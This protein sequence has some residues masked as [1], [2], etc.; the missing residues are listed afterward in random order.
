MVTS[1]GPHQHQPLCDPRAVLAVRDDQARARELGATPPQGRAKQPGP[2]TPGRAIRAEGES[3]GGT[4]QGQAET[5]ARPIAMGQ[6]ARTSAGSVPTG[7]GQPW[8]TAMAMV[9]RSVSQSHSREG[10]T[11]S[12][13]SSQLVLGPSSQN[14]SCL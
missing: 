11:L 9:S 4:G 2:I 12:S 7:L 8:G 1:C 6:Q 10:T 13:T 5:Q 3:W 14:S